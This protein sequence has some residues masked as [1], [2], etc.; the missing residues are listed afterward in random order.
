MTILS[1]LHW[2]SVHYYERKRGRERERE[3][4]E[5]RERE[6]EREGERASER[7]TS[8]FSTI[9]GC[10]SPGRLQG[11]GG[12]EWLAEVCHQDNQR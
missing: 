5:G 3:T 12:D 8:I 7:L 9:L 4:E 10:D 1:Y 11:D 2:F 6:R